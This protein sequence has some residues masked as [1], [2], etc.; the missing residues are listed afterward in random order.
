[1]FTFSQDDS[2]KVGACLTL[3]ESLK[4]PED[5]T[6]AVGDVVKCL[7]EEVIPGTRN[8]VLVYDSNLKRLLLY[9][10]IPVCT[11]FTEGENKRK[12][13]PSSV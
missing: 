4:T 12:E 1:M 9:F 13:F 3:H 2:V 8:E 10:S 5:R 6:R 11:C 7:G